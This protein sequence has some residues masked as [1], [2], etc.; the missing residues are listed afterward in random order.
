[1]LR[2]LYV[3]VPRVCDI[4]VSGSVYIGMHA[5][6]YRILHCLVYRILHCLVYREMHYDMRWRSEH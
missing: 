5:M 6:V 2:D 4:G 1:M 3:S